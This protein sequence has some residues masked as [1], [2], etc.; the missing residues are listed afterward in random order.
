MTRA[1]GAIAAP[2]RSSGLTVDEHASALGRG[3]PAWWKT[4]RGCEASG[5]ARS[6]VVPAP[7]LVVGAIASVQSGAAIATRLFP[8]VGPGGAVFLRLA[9]SAVLLVALAR[10][11]LRATTRPDLVLVVGFGLV[12][13]AMNCLFYLSLARIPL[14]VAVTVEFLGPLGVAVAGSRRALD[15][16]WVLLAAVGVAL[17]ATGGGHLDIVGVAFAASAGAC[18]AAY[19]VA[20]Q[21]VGRAF[22]GMTGLAIAL[23]VGAVAMAPYG[24]VAGGANL[25]RPSVLGKG[26]A[27]AVLSSAIPYSLELAALR[28]LRASVFGVLMSLEPA[29]GAVSGLLFLHQHLR[30]H[31]WLAVGAVMTASIGATAA[32]QTSEPVEVLG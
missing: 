29:M 8:A 4:L 27:I 32:P 15:L 18:W 3:K 11:R 21:R 9:V 6:D 14:G 19:I 28:R 25:V 12:L 2:E 26:A 22:E 17:L 5:V 20:S 7:V 23:V 31:E 24:I 30:W 13:A 16:T 10:P 1:C